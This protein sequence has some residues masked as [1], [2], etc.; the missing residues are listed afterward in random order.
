MLTPS[1]QIT[2]RLG[3][4]KN[5]RMNKLSE[6]REK[7]KKKKKKHQPS[8][9]TYVT[10]LG[11]AWILI[12]CLDLVNRVFRGP[13][14]CSLSHHQVTLITL[15]PHLIPSLCSQEPWEEGREYYPILRFREIGA[16]VWMRMF[17]PSQNSNVLTHIFSLLCYTLHLSYTPTNILITPLFLLKIFNDF[18]LHSESCQPSSACC[19][20]PAIVMATQFVFNIIFPHALLSWR[21]PNLPWASCFCALFCILSSF[22]NTPL[23]LTYA[24]LVLKSLT[25]PIAFSSSFYFSTPQSLS[26]T[27]NIHIHVHTLHQSDFLEYRLCYLFFLYCVTHS[28]CKLCLADRYSLNS[29]RNLTSVELSSCIII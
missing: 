28:F 18:L 16:R 5:I 27:R 10:L 2:L 13:S 26:W 11:S 12:A 20:E 17:N 23:S 8:P 1:K 14:A 6:N 7:K 19:I 25:A 15:I 21:S 22:P 9:L 3:K 24:S 4:Y 29:S